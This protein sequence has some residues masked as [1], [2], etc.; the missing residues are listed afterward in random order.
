VN[1]LHP[2]LIN[3]FSISKFPTFS[4]VCAF[5]FLSPAYLLSKDPREIGHR[6]LMSLGPFSWRFWLFFTVFLVDVSCYYE[7]C[8]L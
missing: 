6:C 7:L 1:D 5:G 2:S 3:G 8:S 4:Y